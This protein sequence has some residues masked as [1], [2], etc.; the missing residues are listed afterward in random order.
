[1]ASK[2]DLS[3]VMAHAAKTF[4]FLDLIVF[5]GTLLGIHRDGHPIDGDDDVDFLVHKDEVGT[6]YDFCYASER[7]QVR[8][9]DERG[10]FLQVVFP[11]YPEIPVDFYGY[12]LSRRHLR[13]KWNFTGGF[14]SMI[15]FLKIPKDTV[16]P[17]TRVDSM[18]NLYKPAE[19]ENVCRTLYGSG[20]D[21]NQRKGLDY[22]S[23]A[24][25]GYIIRLRGFSLVAFKTLVKIFIRD[26]F[27]GK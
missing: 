17:A 27:A 10:P 22:F 8:V 24:I 26:A 21:S 3:R 1:M 11:D 6:L 5:Y 4:P 18:S 7:I 25:F 2:E 13:E 15:F 12:G 23:I 9:Y 14:A 20:W 16:L 19:P